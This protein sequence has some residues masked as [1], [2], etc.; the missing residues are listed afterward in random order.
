MDNCNNL[1]ANDIVPGVG[2][3]IDKGA[4]AAKSVVVNIRNRAKAKKAQKISDA[5]GY[6]T[7]TPFQKSLIPVP[8]YALNSKTPTAEE[9]KNAEPSAVTTGAATPYLPYIIGV[10]IL[11]AVI[12]F[13]K[14]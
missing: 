5:G 10:V 7:L 12:Y 8:S 13:I 6:N 2:G 3:A 9:A 11:A 4:S 1:T 14:K